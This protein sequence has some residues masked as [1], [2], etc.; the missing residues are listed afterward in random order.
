MIEN[1]RLYFQVYWIFSEVI[2]P[3][4]GKIFRQIKKAPWTSFIDSTLLRHKSGVLSIIEINL[5]SILKNDQW[6]DTWPYYSP[7][8]KDQCLCDIFFSLID[9]IC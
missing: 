6:N 3:L 2:E 7:S 5:V 9:V 1:D 8:S 4:S